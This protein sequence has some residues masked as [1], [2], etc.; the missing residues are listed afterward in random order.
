M[1]VLVDAG[2]GHHVVKGIEQ[3]PDV[4]VLRPNLLQKALFSYFVLSRGYDVVH[5]HFLQYEMYAKSSK[6]LSFLRT[7]VFLS[8]LIIMKIG[9]VNIVWTAHHME[10]HESLWPKLDR[11]TRQSVIRLADH[12]IVLSPLIQR[13]LRE[14]YD[15]SS[16][17]SIIRLGNYRKF[18]KSRSAGETTETDYYPDSDLVAIMCGR[19]RPYKRVPLGIA[20]VDASSSV[21]DMLIAG[22][23]TSDCV[24]RDIQSAI[25]E[26]TMPISTHYG[27]VADQDLVRYVE[28][29]EVVL[30]LNDQLTVP[31]TAHLAA[32]CETPIVT[33]PRGEKEALVKNYEVGIVAK[34]VGAENI[35]TAIDKIID[36]DSRFDWSKY[37]ADHSWDVYAQAHIE[38]YADLSAATRTEIL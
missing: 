14:T 22:N 5:I 10:S 8:N 37:R 3:H 16:P 7:L 23:P 19:L 38:I 28:E 12:L 33:V 29:C 18:S 25:Q 9:G 15:V 11:F 21:N 1:K 27:F 24:K 36:E 32:A 17:V 13:E 2:A 31:A 4:D 34:S 26:A 30:I 20:A 6:I 35:A